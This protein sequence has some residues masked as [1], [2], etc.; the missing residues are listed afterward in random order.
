MLRSTFK[1]DDLGEGCVH[2]K[3]QWLGDQLETIQVQARAK[4][5]VEAVGLKEADGLLSRHQ[6]CD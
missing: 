1:S 4:P 6:C 2:G 3:T 5:A